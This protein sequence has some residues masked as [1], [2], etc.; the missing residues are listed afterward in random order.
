MRTIFDP[1]IFF[2]R[3]RYL[4]IFGACG[5]FMPDTANHGIL[6]AFEWGLITMIFNDK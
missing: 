6:F 3:Q 4:P 5:R 1:L 2:G